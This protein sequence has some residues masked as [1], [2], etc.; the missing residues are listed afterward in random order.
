MFSSYTHYTLTV[1][2]RHYM[3][4]RGTRYVARSLIVQFEVRRTRSRLR[5][6]AGA[7]DPRGPLGVALGGVRRPGHV[8]VREPS[9][10]RIVQGPR[11]AGPV[12]VA[13]Q[14]RA[15]DG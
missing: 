13:H 5:D 3:D 9:A 4:V 12:P 14:G 11:P 10:H 8:Q 7:A 6:R 2:R 1:G 15:H